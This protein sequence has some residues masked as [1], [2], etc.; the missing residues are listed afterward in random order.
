MTSGLWKITL[1]NN[2]HD[3]YIKFWAVDLSSM[4]LCKSE[5]TIN[6]SIKYMPLAACQ[7]TWGWVAL[8]SYRLSLCLRCE[9]R[10]GIYISVSMQSPEYEMGEKD[11]YAVCVEMQPHCKALT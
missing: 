1:L 10:D 4:D 3:G 9:W 6:K 5:R 8:L 11:A 2:R 7:L